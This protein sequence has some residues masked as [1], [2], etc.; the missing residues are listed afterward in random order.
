MML[1]VP[2]NNLKSYYLPGKYT[3]TVITLQFNVL[4][5]G[6]A[7]IFSSKKSLIE[8]DPVGIPP[9]TIGWIPQL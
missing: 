5:K 7:F 4:G 6:S 2:Y 8:T 9:M 3:I 1:V